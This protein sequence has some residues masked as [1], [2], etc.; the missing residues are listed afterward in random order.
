MSLQTN[1]NALGQSESG[2][3]FSMSRLLSMDIF[4]LAEHVDTYRNCNTY[5]F[6]AHTVLSCSPKCHLE[7]DGHKNGHFWASMDASYTSD[8]G[9]YVYS[10]VGLVLPALLGSLSLSTSSFQDTSSLYPFWRW[11]ELTLFLVSWSSLSPYPPLSL[12]ACPQCSSVLCLA[13]STE[14]KKTNCGFGVS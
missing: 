5:T 6:I 13:H 2:V 8:I 3:T 14:N 11:A 7:H 10:I 4:S 9:C 12:I 1:R